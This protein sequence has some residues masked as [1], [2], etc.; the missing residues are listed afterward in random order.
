MKIKYLS[1]VLS[2]IGILLLYYLSTVSQPTSIQ[3]NDIEKYEGKEVITTGIV[4]DYYTTSYEN[5]IITIQSNNTSATLFCETPAQLQQGDHIEATGTVQQYQGTW[6]IIVDRPESIRII[7]SWTNI[8]IPLSTLATYPERYIGRNL[9][10]S[11]YIDTRY[12]TYFYITDNE[13]KYQLIVTYTSSFNISIIPGKPCNIH[14]YFTYDP[15]HTC[16]MLRLQSA[17]HYISY[18]PGE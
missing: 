15:S 7:R 6:E 4:T 10:V 8:T 17:N 13:S 11:G 18:Q 2:I 1:L 9:N 3:L 16:Y 5:Q 12:D 14:A